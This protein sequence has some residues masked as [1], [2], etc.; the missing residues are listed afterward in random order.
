M[1]WALSSGASPGAQRHR[2]VTDCTSRG[3]LPPCLRQ[4]FGR[5]SDEVASPL[6]R[7]G[8][9][10]GVPPL[11]KPPISVSAYGVDPSRSAHAHGGL[12]AWSRAVRRPKRRRILC[13]GGKGKTLPPPPQQAPRRGLPGLPLCADAPVVQTRVP[14]P[15]GRAIPLP[16]AAL[17]PLLLRCSPRGRGH[18]RHDPLRG[19]EEK[20]P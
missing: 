8:S 14:R 20:S 16:A 2:R 12:T 6:G 11:P 5:S 18:A 13:G 10:R 3:A 4:V 9:T 15:C 19:E 7:P 17:A 1:G